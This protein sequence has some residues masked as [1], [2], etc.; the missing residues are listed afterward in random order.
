LQHVTA[1]IVE[2]D[3]HAIRAGSVETFA[4][5]TCFVADDIVKACDICNPG[6]LLG[7]AGDTDDPASLDFRYLADQ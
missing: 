4:Q 7:R 1:N 6:T 3:V 2:I 5:V